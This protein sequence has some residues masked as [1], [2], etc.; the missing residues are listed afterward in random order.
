MLYKYLI[1]LLLLISCQDRQETNDSAINFDELSDN[2]NYEYITYLNFENESL[3]NGYHK[4]IKD[5]ADTYK[6]DFQCINHM[7]KDYLNFIRNDKQNYSEEFIE[8]LKY[9]YGELYDFNQD[10]LYH[11]FI[12]FNETFGYYQ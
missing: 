7:L 6:L 1:F 9:H 11:F 3:I 10:D 12:G 2:L 5:L 4:E 8:D